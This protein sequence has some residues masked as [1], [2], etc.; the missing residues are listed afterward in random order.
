MPLFA[1]TFCYTPA[2]FRALRFSDFQRLA[3]HIN[4][5]MERANKAG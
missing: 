2:E 4:E 5:R 1:E 3:H